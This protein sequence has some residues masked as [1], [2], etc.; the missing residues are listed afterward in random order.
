MFFYSMRAATIKFFAV[1]CVALVTLITLIAFVPTYAEPQ[2][3]A[4]SKDG[5]VSFEKI[6]TNEDRIEFLRQFGYEV[7]AEPVTASEVRIP[8]EFDKILLKKE[9]L[10]FMIETSIGIT[11]GGYLKKKIT[12]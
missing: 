12:L 10:V 5:A 2:D 4:V 11:V 9:K 7:E 1:V 8:S 6:K 3:V